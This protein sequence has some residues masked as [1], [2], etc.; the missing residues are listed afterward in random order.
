MSVAPLPTYHRGVGA[1]TRVELFQ[2]P[3]AFSD[4]VAP[5]LEE[6]EVEHCLLLGLLPMLRAGG[7]EGAVMALVTSGQGDPAL[8]ALRTP[9]HRLILSSALDDPDL[10]ATMIALLAALPETPPG[11]LGPPLES[12]AAARAFAAT[13]GARARLDRRDRI[14]VCEEVET[15]PTAPGRMVRAAAEH[16]PLLVSWRVA[17]TQEAL[18]TEPALSEAAAERL[19]MAEAGWRDGGVWLWEW[20]GE[21]VSMAG[22]RGPTRAGIRIGPVYTPP[23]LRGRGY[24]TALTGALTEALLADGRTHVTLFADATNS[25]AIRIYRSLGYQHAGDQHIYDFG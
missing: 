15:R 24:A 4:V 25:A 17:F 8:V 18:P 2:D 13:T 16:M 20:G 19:V 1:G 11:V 14:Y 3:T 23:E 9:P 12:A 7:S 22:A 21:P 10:D 6:R 5:I